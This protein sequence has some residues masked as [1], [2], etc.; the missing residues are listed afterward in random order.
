MGNRAAGGREV[1]GKAIYAVTALSFI[2]IL[3][4]AEVPLTVIEFEHGS[5]KK[6]RIKVGVSVNTLILRE[7]SQQ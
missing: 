2:L 3:F 1:A 7:P 6:S 4:M 5:R